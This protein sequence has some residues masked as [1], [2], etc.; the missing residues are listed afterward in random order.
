MTSSFLTSSIELSS[1]QPLPSVSRSDLLDN[2][3]QFCLL[4]GS[5][6]A[7]YVQGEGGSGKTRL[8]NMLATK[9]R[10]DIESQVCV[11][12]TELEEDW[13]S[14][15]LLVAL[16][17]KMNT[18]K[19]FDKRPT[20]E[21]FTYVYLKLMHDLYPDIV[22][23][24][25]GHGFYSKVENKAESGG[26][27][28]DFASSLLSPESFAEELESL[29]PG[30]KTLI[31]GKDAYK[32]W[33][34]IKKYPALNQ[35]DDLP[36]SELRQKLLRYFIEDLSAWTR[37]SPK[38][39]MILI[40]DNMDALQSPKGRN[41][42]QKII[43][44]L[45]R[46]V[47]DLRGVKLV[48]FGRPDCNWVFTSPHLQDTGKV[49]VTVIGELTHTQARELWRKHNFTNGPLCEKV[50]SGS[51]LPNTIQLKCIWIRNYTEHFGVFP[52]P[53]DMPERLDALYERLLAFRT[54]EERRLMRALA[55]LGRFDQQMVHGLASR[56][57]LSTPIQTGNRLW[58]SASVEKQND[59][60]NNIWGKFHDLLRDHLR[61]PP[62]MTPDQ[63]SQDCSDLC[64]HIVRHLIDERASGAVGDGAFRYG[65]VIHALELVCR[66]GKGW[67]SPV[68]QEL[69]LS[70]LS[71]LNR[72]TGIENRTAMSTIQELLLRAAL[73]IIRQSK[74][75]IRESVHTDFSLRLI[76]E[77]GPIAD[78][79]A[80]LSIGPTASCSAEHA[81]KY[82]DT[83]NGIIEMEQ[84]RA[85]TEARGVKQEMLSL[86]VH[87]IMC[88]RTL[89]P[90]S[91][92][93]MRR[94]ET[95]ELFYELLQPAVNAL[96]E[97]LRTPSAYRKGLSL[98]AGNAFNHLARHLGDT[99]Q[100][101]ECYQKASE[102]FDHALSENPNSVFVRIQRTRH[103]LYPMRQNKIAR[104]TLISA[105]KTL[106]DLIT[107]DVT[108]TEVLHLWVRAKI[109]L[110][111]KVKNGEIE[112]PQPW[113][114]VLDIAEN[115]VLSLH[116]K[117]AGDQAI[118]LRLMLRLMRK[119]HELN[120]PA[121]PHLEGIQKLLATVLVGLPEIPALLFAALLNELRTAIS[122]GMLPKE[123]IVDVLQ[124]ALRNRVLSDWRAI[125]ALDFLEKVIDDSPPNSDQRSSI[126]SKITNWQGL[127][128]DPVGARLKNK[129]I[130]E[131]SEKALE[132]AIKNNDA[133]TSNA[134][135]KISED[136]LKRAN[137]P[138]SILMYGNS[139]LALCDKLFNDCNH[140]VCLALLKG[141]ER[142]FLLY[143]PENLTIY[144]GLLKRKI[145]Y[146]G[147]IL[148]A[149]EL[150]RGRDARETLAKYFM[151]DLHIGSL[152]FAGENMIR[153]SRAEHGARLLF[154]ALAVCESNSNAPKD[155]QNRIRRA[156]AA[157]LWERMQEKNSSYVTSNKIPPPPEAIDNFVQASTVDARAILELLQHQPFPPELRA[158][159]LFVAQMSDLISNKDRNATAFNIFDTE[160]LVKH[161][162]LSIADYHRLFPNSK[163]EDHEEELEA[164]DDEDFTDS[165]QQ[166]HTL[167]NLLRTDKKY[168][169]ASN[170]GEEFITNVLRLFLPGMLHEALGRSNPRSKAVTM[171]GSNSWCVA[172]VHP[173]A[174]NAALA[175]GGY[176]M[177][178]LQK[179]TGIRRITLVPS[180]SI[181]NKLARSNE[182]RHFVNN[183]WKDL[184]IHHDSPRSTVLDVGRIEK[185]LD[186]RKMRNFVSMFE[187]IYPNKYLEFTDQGTHINWYDEMESEEDKISFDDSVI[188]SRIDI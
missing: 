94:I 113:S 91:K 98:T 83:L 129:A 141:W 121:S 88:R 33:D 126:I 85:E 71:T 174:M 103:L 55:L 62:G 87:I 127:E 97:T 100:G 74:Y 105:I 140:E 116:D 160:V 38:N 28:F 122:I 23:N 109:R 39:R 41:E 117:G 67:Q 14:E 15:R 48:L 106:H 104:N 136:F 25:G 32:T 43:S 187:K 184:Q 21:R 102:W 5:A 110:A 156:F 27:L 66:I 132:A 138:N 153:G 84:E 80:Q 123:Q 75:I 9:L 63:Q 89:P 34:L 166:S 57:N 107:N 86:A 115:D 120:A 4:E 59:N 135:L 20:F 50:L 47:L 11:A 163:F 130:R 82:L 46:L 81:L 151:Q 6:T 30:I 101:L 70:I 134:A 69:I 19:F 173:H 139:Q 168:Q 24:F 45:E 150:R 53:E 131:T 54:D 146:F 143:S 17:S 29:T 64:A 37:Q 73:L 68:R 51:L 92:N 77:L 119:R 133:D 159:V 114:D 96:D 42:A 79:I 31:R 148:E 142:Q 58:L 157:Q 144:D 13:S 169:Y 179:L 171:G 60:E 170:R 52:S 22:R 49:S 181:K 155:L 185:P 111:Q 2:L 158:G 149:N 175:G 44:A 145:Q 40:I 177:L 118:N 154:Q 137:H 7:L 72:L 128:Y 35:L 147:H 36:R 112:H 76:K 61:H 188:F 93:N 152:L 167:L 164:E 162:L 95:P 108:N 125:R 183:S 99:D 178:V 165:T 16:I 56:L 124:I 65:A 186:L 26:D 172:R 12:R 176:M 1:E 180:Y 161:S 90:D 78:R 10:T 18:G 8:S 182:L 3:T